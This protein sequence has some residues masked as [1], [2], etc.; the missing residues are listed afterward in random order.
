VF[1]RERTGLTNEELQLCHLAVHIPSNPDFSSLNLAAAVQV[2]AYETRMAVLG[3]I[4]DLGD[5]RLVS[6]RRLTEPPEQA[7][8]GDGDRD[9]RG[10][11][12]RIHDGAALEEEV[13]H[14]VGEDGLH[15][16]L[17]F[18]DERDEVETM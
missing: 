1:G 14:D 9:D 5:E 4:E 6:A 8:A 12:Q 16:L 15:R 13:D 18:E 11:Q 3:G 10:D 7:F 17:K 2:L